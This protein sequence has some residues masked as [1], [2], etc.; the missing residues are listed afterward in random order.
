MW[1]LDP[2]ECSFNL[3]SGPEARL[4][5]RGQAMPKTAPPCALRTTILNQ[6]L[7]GHRMSTRSSQTIP[8]KTKLPQSQ[9]TNTSRPFCHTAHTRVHLISCVG[10]VTTRHNHIRFK[11]WSGC[12]VP[13][14]TLAYSALLT[15]MA[16]PLTC[17]PPIATKR[18][19]KV[20]PHLGHA[21]LS[22]QPGPMPQCPTIGS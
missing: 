7:T 16:S 8:I 5:G 18:G 17:H 19:S 13:S 4:E 9:H 10:R 11:L 3:L 22:P 20:T 12:T 14:I 15:D 1:L 21:H 6:A 2:E